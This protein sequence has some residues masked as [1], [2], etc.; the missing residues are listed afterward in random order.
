[1]RQTFRFFIGPK[2]RIIVYFLGVEAVLKSKLYQLFVNTISNMTIL[3]P[4]GQSKVFNSYVI[5]H[6]CQFSICLTRKVDFGEQYLKLV[7]IQR[8]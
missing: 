8:A 3:W 1:M 6:S 7:F 4:G 5:C 2:T